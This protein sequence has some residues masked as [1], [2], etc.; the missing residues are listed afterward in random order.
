[1]VHPCINVIVH[2]SVIGYIPLLLTVAVVVQHPCGL[3]PWPAQE[4]SYA[5]IV[6]YE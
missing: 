5:T 1:M 2:C 6:R 3:H 4:L